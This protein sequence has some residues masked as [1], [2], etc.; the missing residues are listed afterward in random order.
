[1]NI[2]PTL[3]EKIGFAISVLSVIAAVVLLLKVVKPV[4]RVSVYT[5]SE[6][7]P[8]DIQTPHFPNV[9]VVD[10]Y[11]YR[12]E[13]RDPNVIYQIYEPPTLHGLSLE[14]EALKKELDSIKNIY[15]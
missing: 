8:L 6:P 9:R 2:K 14:V 11:T 15:K 4:E 12:N 3:K 5:V 10:E 7:D 1:M 13:E